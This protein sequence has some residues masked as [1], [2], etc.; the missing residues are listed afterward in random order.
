LVLEI[1]HRSSGDTL[2]ATTGLWETCRG[3]FKRPMEGTVHPPRGNRVILEV[4]PGLGEEAQEKFEGCLRDLTVD[5][6]QADV[7]SSKTWP[8]GG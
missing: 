4:T 1:T 5:H 6:V 8:S 3:R 2:R 7:V